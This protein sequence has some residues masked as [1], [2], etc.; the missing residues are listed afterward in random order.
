[1]DTG[2]LFLETVWFSYASTIVETAIRIYEISEERADEIRFQF[3][4]RGDF[5]VKPK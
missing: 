3:L 2:T 4:K 1:M 5:V